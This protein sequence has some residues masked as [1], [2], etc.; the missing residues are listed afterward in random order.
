MTESV[1]YYLYKN[2]RIRLGYVVENVLLL[3]DGNS[4]TVYKHFK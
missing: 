3:R 1:Y 2:G 4:T